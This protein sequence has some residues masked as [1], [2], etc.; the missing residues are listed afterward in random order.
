LGLEFGV[1]GFGFR[2]SGFGLRDKYRDLRDAPCLR[3]VEGEG[4]GGQEGP[5][6]LHPSERHGQDGAWLRV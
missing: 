2:V 6:R 5:H 3:G 4:R 1:S